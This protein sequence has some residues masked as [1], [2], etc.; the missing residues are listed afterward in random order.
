M[1]AS[2][3]LSIVIQMH[4]GTALRTVGGGRTSRFAMQAEMVDVTNASST[5]QSREILDGAGVK[6]ATISVDGVFIDDQA[7]NGIEASFRN[8]TIRSGTFLVP[9]LGTY[10]ST[11]KCTALEWA[12]DFNK[13][14]TF[15]ATFESAS[16]ITFAT[17]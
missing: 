6:S 3:G 15:S 13:E 14:V 4:D 17:A 1:A 5:G 16:D 9:G 8:Q 2:K 7:A 10:T 11:W 12:G